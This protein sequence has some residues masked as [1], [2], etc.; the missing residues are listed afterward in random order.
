MISQS[1]YDES[2]VDLRLRF[3]RRISF[4]RILGI[5]GLYR[6]PKA[7]RPPPLLLMDVIIDILWP[8]S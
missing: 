7:L 1:A 6:T 3:S 8:E 4:G 2:Y 5:S